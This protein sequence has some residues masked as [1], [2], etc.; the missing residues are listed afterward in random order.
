MSGAATPT[1]IMGSMGGF[2]G[3]M[4]EQVGDQIKG[5]FSQNG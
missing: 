4:N 2:G 5:G 1:G 3:P